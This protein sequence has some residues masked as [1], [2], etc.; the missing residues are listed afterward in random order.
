MGINQLQVVAI[1]HLVLRTANL[2]A[3]LQFYMDVLG[4]RLERE[5]TE[6]GLYQLRAGTGL[7]DLI[8]VDGELGKQGGPAPGPQGNNLDHLCLQIEPET[9][10]DI[11]A[12]L[13]AQGQPVEGFEERYGAQGFGRSLY[14]QDPD[15]NTVELR[16][17]QYS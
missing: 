17:H 14:L 4:C 12:F 15:G 11:L 8:T 2:E 16:C 9:E 13:K 3:M 7:I 10:A 1:D 6:L 5:N